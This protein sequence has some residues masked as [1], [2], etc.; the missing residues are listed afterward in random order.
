MRVLVTGA[1]GF[2][3]S[4]I[5][6]EIPSLGLEAVGTDKTG[7]AG[8]EAADITDKAQLLHVVNQ[9]KP[10]AVLHLAA[11]SGSTGKNEAEQSLRQPHLNFSVNAF[12]TL[13]VVEV[14]R[15]LQVKNILYMS[16]FAVYGRV[17][18][19][20]LPITENT[21]TS[22]EHAYAISKL[23]GEQIVQS[24]S[25]DYGLKS[26]IIRA[27]FIVGERQLERNVVQEFIESARMGKPLVIY[28]SGSHSRE[29]LHPVDLASVFAKAVEYI[30][31]SS[32]HSELFVV[33]NA[34]VTM[35]QL[36][37]KVV[38]EVG[39]GS[40]EFAKMSSDRTFDQVTSTGKARELLSWEPR[41]SI[42]EI[43]HRI[44]SD[45][46]AGNHVTKTTFRDS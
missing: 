40:V 13:N 35:Q 32:L 30:N 43:I 16:T 11:I 4:W 9:V 18:K 1:A 24:Y 39:S 41:I 46:S 38:N 42:D 12:G 27:P 17:A 25:I 20:N 10:D 3:G 29:F 21:P 34:P 44:V 33:G 5:M 19:E 8:I 28:G 14:C 45:Y 37:E 22:P 15:I 7:S 31:G 6:K 26:V 23:Q 36:A 2:V